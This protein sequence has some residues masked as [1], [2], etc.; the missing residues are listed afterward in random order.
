MKR[1]FI[2]K[3]LS[4]IKAITIDFINTKYWEIKPKD[5]ELTA[6]SEIKSKAESQIS[7]FLIWKKPLPETRYN[8]GAAKSS[9]SRDAGKIRLMHFLAE[10]ERCK[11]S[12]SL[13]A[14]ISKYFVG[15]P[16]GNFADTL[17][18]ILEKSMMWVK[19]EH[20]LTTDKRSA[21]L[22]ELWIKARQHVLDHEADLARS[23]IPTIY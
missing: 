1:H 11:D 18:Y 21:E 2:L 13:I 12:D 22:Q 19:P 6:K 5:I 16:T 20:Q 4:E 10:F 14:L 17:A 7:S 15:K 8:L 3:E 9:F 23:S